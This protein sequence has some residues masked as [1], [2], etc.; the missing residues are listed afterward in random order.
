MKLV[1][2][3]PAIADRSVIY[4]YIDKE[5]PRAA[6]EL[7]EGFMGSAERLR[8]YPEI[9]RPGRVPGTREL[10]VHK[11][12]IL[13]YELVGE[14]VFVHAVVHTSRQWPPLSDG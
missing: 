6:A 13:V 12:Y 1:W 2:T 11:R 3:A 10:V 4:D 5:N 8:S 9:G 7:D 14:T